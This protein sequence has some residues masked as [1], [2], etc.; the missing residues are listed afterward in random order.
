MQRWLKTYFRDYR[1]KSLNTSE[2]KQHFLNF[3]ANVEKVPADKLNSIDWDE[4]LN[5][6]GLPSF[7]PKT[8]YDT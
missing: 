2:M 1:F 8:V 7:D 3:F 4:F 5:K 6:P